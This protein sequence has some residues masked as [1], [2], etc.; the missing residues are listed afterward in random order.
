MPSLVAISQARTEINRGDGIPQASSVS[1]RPG[2]IGLNLALEGH[3]VVL[4]GLAGTGKTF[5]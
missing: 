1:N 2:Q 3:N 5:F 4:L